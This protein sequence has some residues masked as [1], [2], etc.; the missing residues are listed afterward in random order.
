MPASPAWAVLECRPQPPLLSHPPAP[1]PP[2]ACIP[3]LQL[4]EEETEYKVACVRHVLESHLVLQFNCTNTVR[5]QV[6]EEV[7]VTVD[8]ADAVSLGGVGRR[9]GAVGAGGV[10]QD[11]RHQLNRLACLH[12][13]EPA[14]ALIARRQW[15]HPGRLLPSPTCPRMR[16]SPACQHPLTLRSPPRPAPPAPQEGFT[17]EAVLP[18]KEMPH[19]GVGQTYVVLAREPGSMALGR[20]LNILRFRVKEID[21]ST[22][23][24][25][26]GQEGWGGGGGVVG[27]Q[28]APAGTGGARRDAR[29]ARGPA[30]RGY[31]R[32]TACASHN[33]CLRVCVQARR[34]RRGTR[35]STSWKM[36][37]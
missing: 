22:G 32:S 23:G 10:R 31:I 19:D 25:A 37:R 30:W 7:S 24:W 16:R 14:R 29:W 5:E 28:V 26:G 1:T 12:H 11:D 6:L 18:L 20:F 15:P 8:L 13:V 21:P 4:T 3:T 34:R 35:T 36:W 9:W 2:P 27:R 33:L 17:E